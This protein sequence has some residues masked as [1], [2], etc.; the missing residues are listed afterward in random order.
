MAAEID[1]E[2]CVFCQEKTSEELECPANTKRNDRGQG[3]ATLETIIKK[4]QE[5]DALPKNIILKHFSVEV[6][7]QNCASWHKR[8]RVKYSTPILKRV[9]SKKRKQIDEKATRSST[10]SARKSENDD[11]CLICDEIVE[12]CDIYR[13]VAATHNLDEKVRKCATDLGN[14]KLIAK[15]SEGD[16]IAIDA[17]YH[18]NCLTA[19]YKK[20]AKFVESRDET[21]AT[22]NVHGIVLA[23]LVS[24]INESRKDSSINTFKMTDLAHLYKE[25]LLSLGVEDEN[26]HVTRLKNRILAQIP[27]LVCHTDKHS[28]GQSTSLMFKDDVDSMVDDAVTGI[29]YDNEALQLAKAAEIVR[30]E[31]F[32][33]KQQFSGS[34]SPDCQGSSVPSSLIALVEMVLH[35]PNIRNRQN[36]S[37]LNHTLSIAQLMLFNSV[38]YAKKEQ[39]TGCGRHTTDRETPLPLYV[40]LKIHTLTRSKELVDIMYKLGMS[41][42]YERIL[43]VLTNIANGVCEQFEAE[44]IVCP[45]NL[46][47]KLFTVAALDNI[48]H[49]P[50]AT[51]THD[52]FHGTS[53][54][55]FQCPTS[56]NRGTERNPISLEKQHY[57]KKVFNL[58]Q[59]YTDIAPARL[60]T[61]R[62]FVPQMTGSI[63]P[64]RNVFP[65][66]MDKEYEWLYH[67]R[68]LYKKNSLTTEDFISWAA[69]HATRQPQVP[70]DVAIGAMLP[71]FYENSHSVAMIKHGMKVVSKVVQ[72]LNPGQVPVM[73]VDQPLYA[74]AKQVQWCWPDNYGEDKFVIMLGG[75]HIEMA[76]LRT[77]GTWLKGSGWVEVIVRSGIATPGTAESFERASHV[78][79]T[80]RSHQITAASLSIL[81]QLAY[82]TYTEV[83]DQEET[84]DFEAWR[85]M[86]KGQSPQFLFWHLTMEFQLLILAF[87]RAQREGIFSLY[88]QTL[89]MLMPWMFALDSTHYAR[90]L[91]VHI[92]DMTMLSILHPEIYEQFQHGQFVLHKTLN[93]FSGMAID[94]CHEQNNAIIKGT[95]G[96]VGLTENPSALRRWTVAG[97]ELARLL[98]EFEQSVKSDITKKHSHHEQ[99]P[100]TQ[101]QFRDKINVMVNTF[102]EMGN[103]FNDASDAL[104]TLDGKDIMDTAVVQS[105]KKVIDIGQTKYETYISERLESSLRPIT[106]TIPK[107]NLPLFSKRKRS[108]KSKAQLKV[109]TLQDNVAL[110]SELYI[111]CQT[112]SINMDDFFM[113][114]NQPYP[115]SLSEYGKLRLGKKSDLVDCLLQPDLMK[116]TEAP[117]GDA[118]IFDGAALVHFL[119]PKTVCTF[120]EY[121]EQIFL[122]YIDRQHAQRVDIVWD[123]YFPE[124]LKESA[125]EKRGKGDR[126]RVLK[127]SKIPKSWNKFLLNQDNK[128]E[129]FGFLTTYIRDN[130]QTKE[131]YATCGESVICTRENADCT[132][133]QPCN[134]EEADS[135]IFI[136]A[137]DAARKGCKRLLIRTVD[138]DVVVLAI[139]NFVKLEIDELWVEYGLGKHLRYI[140][141]HIIAANLGV[142]KS[143]AIAGFH[144]FTGCDTV[145]CFAGKGKKSA[146]DVWRVF[147]DV[148]QAF[149]AL[150]A[151]LS[152]V[153]DEMYQLLER[154]V[155]LLYDRTSSCISLDDSRKELFTKRFRRNIENLPPTTAAFR[156]HVKRAAYQS[157]HVWG[158]ILVPEMKLPCPSEWGWARTTQGYEPYWTTLPSAGR[159]CRELKKCS[160]TSSCSNR[161]GCAKSLLVCTPMCNCVCEET[162]LM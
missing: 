114:E 152:S 85:D 57:G 48:D 89:N 44:N 12:H 6:L 160:C 129:L 88:L 70:Q 125:R 28:K 141:A 105:V 58:P 95:G 69:F 121:A 127:T 54:S 161:C 119:E 1:W 16:V 22:N 124:S 59:D 162:L 101:N 19:L 142:H 32:Q 73:T 53:I 11:L 146:W 104:M 77:L 83:N 150:S 145:S 66:V 26:I 139:A 135:R 118:K 94:Q 93:R 111:A 2:K 29:D 140:P 65:D 82:Q 27:D 5:A 147:P 110:F 62:P 84:M 117:A 55:V 112:R 108:T 17:V 60:L 38:K 99:I 133:I 76:A 14:S 100:S 71:M 51:T 79:K 63:K 126:R 103:P 122:P 7:S 4:F 115:P 18:A 24:Y 132:N 109:G 130:F 20:H 106:D 156:Q 64:S 21:V 78:T 45:M 116:Y 68:D 23:E 25:R 86:R 36:S 15:L 8:C 10:K 41:V 153:S 144:S 39:K 157:G 98:T 30:H 56:L 123:R 159:G 75:L 148:T 50:S 137:R 155:I 61:S 42:S 138:T 128:T 131:V 9:Q 13:R 52:S 92:R 34:F 37:T 47:H 154:F 90:W 149:C 97:P 143:Q 102:E 81:Q 134:H 46:K 72:F 113:H 107:S 40:G 33:V 91:P 87:V 31:M 120:G 158:Q 49:N 43:Q 136:H 74:L 35:G 96:A 67:V 151:P 3:Y 80:R